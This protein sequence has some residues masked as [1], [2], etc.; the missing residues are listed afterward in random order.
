MSEVKM[1][2]VCRKDLNCRKGKMMAQVA[3]A[4]V[5]AVLNLGIFNASNC[6][7]TIPMDSIY[8]WFNGLSTKICVGVNSK[9][10]LLQIADKAKENGL[11]IALVEDAGR[12]EF[13]GVPTL[14]CLAIGPAKGELIDQVTG[15]L[16]LL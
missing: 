1:V 2:I 14:T 12:T 15:H 11:P 3:H 6:T 4:A 13:H 5:N 7:I 10:E 8:E 16:T 9:E